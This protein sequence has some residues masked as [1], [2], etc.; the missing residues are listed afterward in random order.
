MSYVSSAWAVTSPRRP[1]QSEQPIT[2]CRYLSDRPERPAPQLSSPPERPTPPPVRQTSEA[3]TSPPVQQT[4]E[5]PHHHL[6]GRHERP[7]T[8]ARGQ[9]R[10]SGGVAGTAGS[11]TCRAR[12]VGAAGRELT[13]V[14]LESAGSARHGPI[15]WRSVCSPGDGRGRLNFAGMETR[16]IEHLSRLSC[17]SE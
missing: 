13:G 5:A 12:P 3:H 17:R 9:A 7:H 1:E 4:S 2:S 14:N 11:A 8:P 6:S 10:V 16:G 15:W